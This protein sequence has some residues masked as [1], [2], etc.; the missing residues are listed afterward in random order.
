MR[1]RSSTQPYYICMYLYCLMRYLWYADIEQCMGLGL[2]CGVSGS[3]EGCLKTDL[4]LEFIFI[5]YWL[6]VKSLY[7]EYP[8]IKTLDFER[9]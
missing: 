5:S 4:Y 9:K 7:S 8:K 2:D 6:Y 1:M 3:G